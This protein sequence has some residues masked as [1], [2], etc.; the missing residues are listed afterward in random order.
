MKLENYAM[1]TWRAGGGDGQMLTS[2]VDGRSIASLT[3]DGLDFAAMLDYA[4]RVGGM[5]LRRHTFH[6]R[7][8]M[9]KALAKHLT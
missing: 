2:A 9:L 7:A 6:E 8:L 5:N 3:S 4:R 1:N